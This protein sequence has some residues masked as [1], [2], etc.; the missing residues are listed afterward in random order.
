M[1][2]DT[3]K[4]VKNL[5]KGMSGM[6]KSV[7][8]SYRRKRRLKILKQWLL[9]FSTDSHINTCTK[10]HDSGSQAHPTSPNLQHKE[11]S[12]AG[13]AIVWT[14]TVY[15]FLT[16]NPYW[17]KNHV[18][19]IHLRRE[20]SQTTKRDWQQNW[21]NTSFSRPT[22][23]PRKPNQLKDEKR[24]RRWQGVPQC[25]TD[26]AFEGMPRTPR[27]KKKIDIVLKDI[28]TTRLYWRQTHRQDDDQPKVLLHVQLPETIIRPKKKQRNMRFKTPQALIHKCKSPL[29]SHTPRY[30]WTTRDSLATRAPP[31]SKEALPDTRNPQ[32][33]IF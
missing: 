10:N 29:Y 32:T 21:H 27:V 23:L 20:D 14:G 22:S 16:Q 33:E 12:T 31:K 26:I 17:A 3:N 25:Q 7:A 13:D 9:Q 24:E 28:T 19:H 4:V 18:R 11:E 2:P 15:I 8:A 6:S 5:T 1:K 30:M